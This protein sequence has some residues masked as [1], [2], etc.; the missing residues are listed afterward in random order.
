MA[1]GIGGVHERIAERKIEI[2]ASL[3]NA[4]TDYASDGLHNNMD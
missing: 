2:L 1:L 3:L 4:K